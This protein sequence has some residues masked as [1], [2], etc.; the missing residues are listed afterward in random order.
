M[1][2]KHDAAVKL[3]ETAE[4]KLAAAFKKVGGDDDEADDAMNG[5]GLDGAEESTAA[6][7]AQLELLGVGQKSFVGYLKE[8]PTCPR[9]LAATEEIKEA[10]AGKRK[11][12]NCSRSPG[13]RRRSLANKVVRPNADKDAAIAALKQACL[14]EEV[15]AARAEAARAK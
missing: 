4:K 11:E 5:S 10:I 1:Q 2:K 3:A 7:Q 9:L 8:R 15:A 13:D 14:D 6:I 12:L